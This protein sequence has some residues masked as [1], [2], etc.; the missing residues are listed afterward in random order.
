MDDAQF[1]ELAA[2]VSDAGLRGLDETTLVTEFC[3]RLVAQGLPLTRAQVFIDTLHP[4]YGGRAY[5][6]HAA[7]AETTASEYA[8]LS[9]EQMLARWQQ[10]R[11]FIWS[12]PAARCCGVS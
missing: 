5:A 9:D 12:R 4:T 6:W 2:W 3:A 1:A 8:Q 10:T 7:K 11:S